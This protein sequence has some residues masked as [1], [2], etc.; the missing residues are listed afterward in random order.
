MPILEATGSDFERVH[1][2]PKTYK[3]ILVGVKEGE[4][5]DMDNPGTKK[6]VLFW[7]FEIKGREKTVTVEGMTTFSFFG[8]KSKAR[9]W[10]SALLNG[11]PPSRIDTDDLLGYAC[12]VVVVDKSHNNEVFSRVESVVSA[13]EGEL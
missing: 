5:N 12:R 13:E 9:K 2:P 1:I 7:A 10:V 4:I 11:E 3:A 6:R 8:E